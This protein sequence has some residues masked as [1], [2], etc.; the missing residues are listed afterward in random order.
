MWLN[1]LLT[2]RRMN[3]LN[4][5]DYEKR[6]KRKHLV[7][8]LLSFKMSAVVF[9]STVFLSFVSNE[10][11]ALTG[12]PSQ[13]E[14][15]SFTPA[16]TSEMVDPFT[17]DFSYNIP[18]LDVE[19]YP[20]NLAYSSGISMDQEA[21]WVGLGW[22]VNTGVINRT[23]RGLPDDFMGDVVTTT[24]SSKKNI[25]FGLNVGTKY[26]LFGNPLT[27]ENAGV[28][29][30]VGSV[31]L[32][33][34][35]KLGFNW[36]NY[37]GVGVELGISPEFAI[38][39]TNGT[40]FTAGL[41]LSSTSGGGLDIAP[42][43][44]LNQH[45]GQKTNSALGLSESKLG[46]GISSSFN[47]RSG[48]SHL[49]MSATFKGANDKGNLKRSGNSVD[50]G[51]SFDY[52][53]PT[54]TPFT[55]ANQKS[56][57]ISGNFML[58]SVEFL[59]ANPGLNLGGYYSQQWIPDDEK[60]MN[61]PA[62]GYFHL[63]RIGNNNTTALQDFNRENDG[64]YTSK[65]PLLSM[66]SLT[67][68]YFSVSGQG[69]S[70]SYRP[71]RGEIGNVYDPVSESGSLGGNA[72]L[73]FGLGKLVKW[74]V[75][76]GV[77][78]SKTE[79]GKW[80]HNNMADD[81]TSYKSS[82]PYELYENYYLKEASE[83]SVSSDPTYLSRMG[84]NKAVRFDLDAIGANDTRVNKKLEDRYNSYQNLSTSSAYRHKREKRNNVLSILSNAEVSDGFGLAGYPSGAQ[85]NSAQDHHIGQ[86]TALGG[87]GSRYVY[88]LPAYNTLKKEVTFA[89]GDKTIGTGSNNEFPNS[90]DCATG[91]IEYTPNADNTQ[92]NDWG[93]DNFFN[94]VE[95]PGYAHAFMLTSVISPDYVDIDNVKGPSDGDLGSYTR[96]YYKQIDDFKWR[97]PFQ[98][99]KAQY[100]EGLKSDFYDDKANYIYGE[101]ELWY[102]DS[103]VTKNYIAIFHTDD[104]EDACS[105]LG[106]NGGI[107]ATKSMQKLT[108]ISLY[109]KPEYRANG[110]NATPIKEV[111]FEYSY[112]LC[113]GVPNNT[114][115]SHDHDGDPGTPNVSNEGGKLTLER[116]YFTYRGSQKGA[117]SDYEFTYGDNNNYS[118]NMK[119]Y[120]RWGTYKYN[121]NTSSCDYADDSLN[122]SDFPY[123]QQDDRSLQDEYASAW[124][125]T[126]VDLPSG[127]KIVVEYESDD[128]A[129]VQHKK[130]MQM[131]KITSVMNGA[132]QADTASSGVTSISDGSNKNWT[133]RFDIDPDNSNMDDYFQDVDE[134]YFRCLMEYDEPGGG[135]DGRYDYV[136]GYAKIDDYGYANGRGW[137]KLQSV[138]LGD[139]ETGDYNPIALAG[140][141]YGR[142]HLSK[143]VY[144]QP[145]L[146]ENDGFGPQLLNSF[147][148]SLTNIKDGFKN[149]NKSVWQKERGT[150]LVIGKSWIRLNNVDGHKLGGGLRVKSIRTYDNWDE[151][152]SNQMDEFSY[153]QEYIYED[154]DGN[155]SGVAA[156]EPQLGGEENPWKQPISYSEENKLAPDNRFYKETP[157]GESFFPSASVGYSRVTIKNLS[158]D[159]VKAHAT[160]KVIKEFYTA[161]NYPTIVSYTDVEKIRQKSGPFSLTSL[162]NINKK[163]FMTASQGF[164]V[165]C[166]DM[167]GK[168]SAERVYA[169]DKTEPITSVE[170][171]YKDT[172][173]SGASRMLTNEATVINK[174]GSS[175]AGELGVFFDMVADY[176][177]SYVETKSAGI[178][179]NGDMFS[180]GVIPVLVPTSFGSFKSEK[181]R[182]R[183]ATTTKVIQRF[184]ILDSTVAKD[185]G[186]VVSTKNLAY[187]S[188]TGEV[189]LTQTQTNFEDAVYSLK[190]PAYWYY[191]GMG[192][193]YK[194][195]GYEKDL[196]FGTN[197]VASL[198]NADQYFTPGDELLL[199]DMAMKAW[200]VDVSSTEVQAINW[201]GAPILGTSSA[202]VIR[203]GRRNMQ[204]LPMA[205]ITT[206]SN[207][208]TMLSSNVYE[209]VLQAS[210]I[211]YGD[212]W[213]TVCNCF[214]FSA[215][216]INSTNPYYIGTKGNFRPKTSYLHLSGRTQAS[217]NNNTD[218][219]NDG[220]FVSYTPFYKLNAANEWE[221]D[222]QDWTYTAEVTEFNPF[223]QELENEDALGR[224]SAATFGFNQTL[225]MAVGANA[226]N[227]E[228]GFESFEDYN[229]SPCADDH[230]KFDPDSVNVVDDD[231]HTGRYSI[232][233]SSGTSAVLSRDLDEWC[234]PLTC[235]LDIDTTM[236][237][238]GM[239]TDIIVFSPLD[240]ASP[241][242]LEWDVI[243]G[244]PIVDYDPAAYEISVDLTGNYR[245]K[246]KY[247]DD[248]NCEIIK[249]IKVVGGTVVSIH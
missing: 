222:K 237:D 199:A 23:V 156:Y 52:G 21:S 97:V 180:V 66:A 67:N 158:H 151:M 13:P 70:G 169:E 101:K 243:N 150:K 167:H 207:P 124:T 206:R 234:A 192:P 83:K 95:T 68:D 6:L 82:S 54:Y 164:T 60:E 84:G 247:R 65:T 157:V 186:S 213:R 24:T 218:I 162:L 72:G 214:D 189:L 175:Q 249:T 64:A 244:S 136:S 73:Q 138:S 69:V 241:Y 176:R 182:F 103:I 33:L 80:N 148:S 208:L 31:G 39:K 172:P 41:G 99:N 147:V 116:V 168:P 117:H 43:V 25:T 174:D 197:G 102:L 200:V 236:T 55:T 238:D 223:G 27:E 58:A 22:N 185:L 11:K 96:F 109:S 240:G 37:N 63:D 177:Q 125:L 204:Q 230:F 141:Q 224:Y 153:G 202:R 108:K 50:G 62:Y 143:Y 139:N 105:A 89:V 104:R 190:Y 205:S 45:L 119:G 15:S 47:S 122:T 146:S 130:A 112:R 226:Q 212:A 183:S 216:T 193:A 113:P 61:N 221:I 40:E 196:T 178:Q 133:L 1:S 46:G 42:S 137:V 219:R 210:A 171:Y 235:E 239:G 71:F 10:S 248:N 35:V 166:N 163:D 106:E 129:Y 85:A 245:I 194:N 173:Y 81:V 145:A 225:A 231:S 233:V 30:T 144:D 140:V 121:P 93:V 115:S 38:G 160:G 3:Y 90:P 170:Y 142:L 49:A 229:F 5:I 161:K 152:T 59:G 48:L 184:G 53:Q 16:G 159:N 242:Q 34:G 215:G 187:D 181:N 87:D 56:I 75:D 203:S 114:G 209:N 86:M 57:S 94:S 2:I 232:K 154:E 123:T 188:E 100:N 246:V 76:V 91:L 134:L 201:E 111:H 12:G 77:N 198:N 126:E 32:D 120:D 227:R 14:V 217:Y 98:A 36:S 78:W 107:D 127:G 28:L 179:L 132:N 26:E 149:P 191:D 44:S 29:D 7:L 8:K 17:G 118:Y 19:G 135:F 18:L 79:T 4:R 74:G 165:I 20:I 155:S 110:V 228:I 51:T 131:Y 211:E 128:Y 92:S 220:M 9:L 195:I 88:G